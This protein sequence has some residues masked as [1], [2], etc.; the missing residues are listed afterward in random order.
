MAAINIAPIMDAPTSHAPAVPLVVCPEQPYILRKGAVKGF[1]KGV[2][3]SALGFVEGHKNPSKIMCVR[4]H[5]EHVA[6][7]FFDNPV[8]SF[9]F[10]D[11]SGLTKR[12]HFSHT[13]TN[14]APSPYI[15]LWVPSYSFT[16]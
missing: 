7:G 1:D 4:P 6:F 8:I 5:F 15:I 3:G 14:V 13:G 12:P 11:L 10:T 16:G 9:T 2:S